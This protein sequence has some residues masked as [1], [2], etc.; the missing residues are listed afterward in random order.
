MKFDA[1]TRWF[2]RRSA[3]LKPGGLQDGIRAFTLIEMLVVITIIAVVAT[4]GIPHLKGWGEADAMTAATRQL[5]DDLSLARLKAINNRATVYVVFVSPDIAK[6]K[7]LKAQDAAV[8]TNLFNGQYTTYA[9]FSK[10]QAGEQP[11]RENPKY[12]TSWKSLPE[13]TFIAAS[14][15]VPPG[16]ASRFNAAYSETNRPFGYELIPFPNATN[17]P[18][19]M[20]CIAFN[21]QG[22]LISEDEDPTGV[23]HYHEAV[24]PLAS[25]SIF[26]ARDAE[27][28]PL[29]GK[30]D[31]VETP[32]RN[33]VSNY[34]NIRI[35]WLTGRARLERREMQ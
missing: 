24:I 2:L 25:G 21:S 6:G 20:P 31:A 14:K 7:F 17:T 27:G 26:Y 35:D 16:R 13:K 18:V 32:P 19:L 8:A 15:F 34:N 22:Q 1:T 5:M 28:H 12:L 9:L 11:G 3:G 29:M 33:S 10:R 4:I 23:H 30:A